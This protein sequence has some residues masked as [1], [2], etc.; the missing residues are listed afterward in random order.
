M[1]TTRSLTL[2]GGLAVALVAAGAIASQRWSV[3]DLGL[4][5]PGVRDPQTV[6][7]LQ[8]Q[9]VAS[10]VAVVGTIE[11][12]SVLNVAAPFEALV[13]DKPFT[14]GS[15]V[16]RGDLLLR[17]DTAEQQT[18]LRDARSAQIKARQRVAELRGWTSGPEVAR[19]RRSLAALEMDAGELRS[20]IAQTKTLLDRGIVAAEEYR[21]LLAQQRSQALQIQASREDLDQA[22]ARGDA[23][24]LRIAEFELANA[25]AR[26]G[27]LEAELALAEIRAPVA[28]VVMPAQD[29][30]GAGNRRAPIEQGS[31]INKGQTLLTI[32]D[33][34][35]LT[36][37][38]N[39][40]E[41][42]VNKVQLGQPVSV[43]GDALGDEPLRGRVAAIAAQA[44]SEAGR[45]GMPAFP[46][47]VR[48]D[49]MTPEQA[50]RIRVGMSANLSITAYE[51]PAALVVPPLAI[52][53]EGG[54]KQVQVRT[55]GV[56]LHVPVVLGIS[57][58]G[59]VEV[60]EG[61]RA[62]DVVVLDPD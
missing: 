26:V 5:G 35:A 28:G 54:G 48:I 45:T 14:Y 19:A 7:T 23:D 58:P 10:L 62:G 11:A 57:T 33:L 1:S 31:R 29:Y 9:P 6:I 61:L 30:E 17:L 32:G 27:E 3:A 36:V 20:R 51:N 16:G 46:V 18:R 37:R 50:R 41:I 40:D 22:L 49:S 38:G 34:E 60:R 24:V 53:S 43:T 52:H 42:D 59:G 21:G 15:R 39:L 8:P 47:L 13:R 12:G 44:S 4:T 55:G 2:T 25:D 56:T